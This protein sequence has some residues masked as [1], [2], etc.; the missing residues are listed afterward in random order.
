MRINIY[1]TTLVKERG[2]NY[3]SSQIS[4]TES[5]YKLL[6]DVCH[7]DRLPEEH[8]YLICLTS[9]AKVAGIH[10]LSVGDLSS[11]IVHPRSVYQRAILN[12]SY[13]IIVA[14]NHP[15]GDPTPSPDDIRTTQ[16]L[17]E[18]G[19][20]LGIKLLDHIIVGDGAYTSLR[21]EGIL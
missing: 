14:H 4:D 2:I 19:E 18:A 12:N 3:A 16:R 8:C 17:E 6:C 5:L 21:A 15:S 20:I 11:S 7:M 10:E 1:R 13:A 9:K